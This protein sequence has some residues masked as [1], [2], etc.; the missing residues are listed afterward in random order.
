MNKPLVSF[1]LFT[2]NQEKYILDAIKGAFDQTYDNLEIIISDD[3]SKDNTYQLIEEAV[4]EYK[5]PHKVIVNRNQTNLGIAQHVNKLLYE[6][7]KGE[8]IVI[9]AGDDVSMPTRTEVC[10]DFLLQHPEVSSVSLSSEEC[11][12]HLQPKHNTFRKLMTPGR[13]SIVTLEDYVYF[14]DF[15]LFPGDSRVLRRSVI[16][17]FPPLKYVSAEDIYLFF[18]SL[19]IGSVGYIRQPLVKYRIYGGNITCQKQIDVAVLEQKKT[20]ARLQFEE[21]MKLALQNHYISEID[22]PL[23]EQKISYLVNWLY[24]ILKAQKKHSY[25]YKLLRKFAKILFRE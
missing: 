7:A 2:Y 10:V 22:I 17:S 14:D 21:D 9:A 25:C 18:R 5:G 20:S 11:D 16:E 3:C 23:I 4:S 13:N 19:L 15:I 1:C 8:I 6:L 24:P 12:E